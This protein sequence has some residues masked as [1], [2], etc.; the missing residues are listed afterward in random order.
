MLITKYVALTVS[1]MFE[2]LGR[3]SV[4]RIS[5]ITSEININVKKIMQRDD[6]VKKYEIIQFRK[7]K[8]FVNINN[9]SRTGLKWTVS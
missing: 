7:G 8:V 3:L 2:F 9:F 6:Y 4:I 5:E 1:T